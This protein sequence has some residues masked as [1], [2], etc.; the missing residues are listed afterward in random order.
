VCREIDQP[1]ED[2]VAHRAPFAAGPGR[3]LHDRDVVVSEERQEVDPAVRCRQFR[4]PAANARRPVGGGRREIGLA[5]PSEP[6]ERTEGGDPHRRFGAGEPG[7]GGGEIRR[8]A[9][10]HDLAPARTGHR[11]VVRVVRVVNVVNA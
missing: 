6:V 8:V 4:R 10:D 11:R 5:Q 9:G 3:D 2:G 7:A 1:T